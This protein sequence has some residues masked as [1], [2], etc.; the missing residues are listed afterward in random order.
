[1]SRVESLG[2]VSFGL[3]G[4][5]A[6]GGIGMRSDWIRG[7]VLVPD[8]NDRMKE[9]DRAINISQIVAVEFREDFANVMLSNHEEGGHPWISLR[10]DLLR[11]F[12][13][14]TGLGPTDA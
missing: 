3:R 2:S 7:T 4:I 11:Q 14:A 13:E 12:L 10:G 8:G 1:M 9:T 6:I 5:F